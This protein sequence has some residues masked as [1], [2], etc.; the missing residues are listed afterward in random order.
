MVS[1]GGSSACARSFGLFD[2]VRIDHFRGFE[3]CWQI[4]ADEDTAIN[5]RW[6]PA[7]GEALFQALQNEFGTL[8]VVAE[9]LGL[10]H[11]GRATACAN[12]S[13]CRA[14]ASCSSPSMASRTIRIC[15]TT[16]R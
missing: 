6:V 15:R 14:C 12:S 7:P 3:A 11:P 16:M 1:A 13:G 8:P 10:H 2:L 4:P 5:G 9:D